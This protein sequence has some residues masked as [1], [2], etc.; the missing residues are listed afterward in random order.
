MTLINNPILSGFN[1]DPSICRVGEDYYIAT[2]TFEWFPGVQIHHSKD[3]VH[4]ELIAHP[5][6]RISQL[7]MLG[8]AD[9]TGIWAPCLTFDNG[10]FYLIYT[11]VKNKNRMKDAPNYLVTATDIRG[12]WSEPIYLNCS[13]FDPSLF[14]DQDGRKW[15][16]NM[17]WDTRHGKNHFA[18]TLLQEYDPNKKCLVGP[19]TNIF[20]GTA[21]G[22]TE[23]PH[24]YQLNGYYYLLVAEGGTGY[25]HAVSLARSKNLEGPYEVHPQNPVLTAHGTDFDTTLLQKAG[26]ASLTDTGN[27]EWVMVHLCSRPLPGTDR[28]VLGRE[29]A[30]QNVE[31]RE[32]G[33]L[34]L[35]QGGQ[36]P[37]SEV[38]VPQLPLKP[39]V[40][41]NP[42]VDEF[43]DTRLGIHW[44]TLRI[45]P[46]EQLLS[47]TAKP[48][49]LRLYGRQ[50]LESN[51]VQS[52]VARRQ[53]SFSYTAE[54]QLLFTPETSLHM[55]GL[56]CYYNTSN[57]YY[58]RVTF[59]E[60]LQKMCIG[61]LASLNS[62]ESPSML[63]DD[64]IFFE[65]AGAIDLKVVVNYSK[66]QFFY[67]LGLTSWLPIGPEYDASTL[68]DD[69]AYLRDY[70]FT[71]AFVGLCC[72]DLAY[73]GHPADFS[74]FKYEQK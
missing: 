28:C 60:D 50:S 45:P 63:H 14:H 36:H 6:N 65:D 70:A 10:L 9:S 25:E 58:L 48:G 31:W 67:R 21:L 49:Y 22:C 37:Y 16:V 38:Q 55:A 24:L 15:L 47:L 56:V 29:T 12:E 33:W 52:L 71:G 59:D 1:P 23:G 19:I 4:W 54:T 7:D 39:Y 62:D 20:K 73:G 18:G 51:F 11:N 68:S 57:Y 64:N 34:Y 2:S 44:N 26:H 43:Q 66:L 17:K 61:V 3:L 8:T 13:G 35:T 32:D 53:Q 74:Y 69:F 5:L 27:G 42:F 40:V 30:L 46:T 41:E 72:Q